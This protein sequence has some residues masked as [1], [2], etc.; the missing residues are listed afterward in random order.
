MS[1]RMLNPFRPGQHLTWPTRGRGNRGA[2]GWAPRPTFLCRVH[3]RHGAEGPFPLVVVHPHFHFVGGEGRQGLV[4]KDVSGGVW[5]GHDGLHPA[6]GAEGAEGHHVAKATSVLQ[7][8]GH[9]LGAG[10]Q[11]ENSEIHA[12]ISIPLLLLVPSKITVL[13]KDLEWEAAGILLCI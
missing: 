6:D 12:F 4:A 2:V 5:G 3:D 9:R 10:K 11:R 13:S 8:L 1:V 7:L